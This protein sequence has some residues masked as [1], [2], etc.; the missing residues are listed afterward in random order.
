MVGLNL[1]I[2]SYME[3]K[4]VQAEPAIRLSSVEMLN[5]SICLRLVHYPLDHS[6]SNI[7]Y[8]DGPDLT[9]SIAR[10]SSRFLTLAHELYHMYTWITYGTM[11]PKLNHELQT[12]HSA[13]FAIWFNAH[14]KELRNFC[15]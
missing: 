9:V 2:H 14:S 8:A 13:N 1:Q 10:V 11:N 6:L 5:Y 12:Q 4:F 3:L 7:G 15:R